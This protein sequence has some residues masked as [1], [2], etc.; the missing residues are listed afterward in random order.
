MGHTKTQII[1]IMRSHLQIETHFF[2]IY[3]F[4]CIYCFFYLNSG[5]SYEYE[6]PRTSKGF[7]FNFLPLARSFPDVGRQPSQDGPRSQSTVVDSRSNLQKAISRMKWVDHE[8][9]HREPLTG[10]TRSPRL[11]R[12]TSLPG[13][14]LPETY[15]RRPTS[16]LSPS[17]RLITS[18]FYVI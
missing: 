18:Y 3:I 17:F 16:H 10:G 7:A 15:S 12:H 6:L 9:R 4:I 5:V 11:S 8:G 13:S 14:N 1:E 2:Y